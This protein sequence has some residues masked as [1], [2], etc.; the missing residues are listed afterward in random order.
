MYI[1]LT[2]TILVQFFKNYKNHSMKKRII[3]LVFTL[4]ANFLAA[5]NHPPN[6]QILYLYKSASFDDGVV[7]NIADADG[8]TMTAS[9]FLIDEIG[10]Y[11]FLYS[12]ACQEGENTFTYDDSNIA[13]TVEGAMIS[14]TDHQPIDIAEIVALVS[15]DSLLYYMSA[16]EGIR[17]RTTGLTHLED[18]KAG[19]IDNFNTFGLDVRTQDWAYGSYTA[20]NILGKH[21]GHTEPNKL[22]IH[23]AHFDSVSNGPGA[24]DNGSG[25]IGVI[26]AARVLSKFQFKKSLQFIGF[27]LEED[28]LVGSIKYLTQSGGLLASEQLE[29]VLNNE[30]IGYYRTEAG[31]QEMPTGFNILF[32]ATYAAVEQDSFRGNFITNVGNAASQSLI[33]AYHDAAAQYA[34]ELRVLDI[35]APGNSQ[36][37]P[38]LRRSDHAP[39]WDAGYQ[40]LMLTDGSEYRNNNYHTPLDVSDSLNFDFMTNVVRA[41]I[42]TLATLAQPIS[43]GSDTTTNILITMST[44][45][46]NAPKW[47]IQPNPVISTFSIVSSGT[48]KVSATYTVFDIQGKSLKTGQLPIGTSNQQ[49]D[50]ADLP[51]GQYLLQIIGS[52]KTLCVTPIVKE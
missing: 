21:V 8:D 22:L 26:E 23:D 42:A 5:Q 45:E 44:K 30:M 2:S 35:A 41:N 27:D 6:V 11:H 24:D 12:V 50:I 49:V 14:V 47:L 18:V 3:Y 25:T 46:V 38:D 39:F 15:E 17:N 52:D 51:A 40:A 16:I 32:P 9:V 36:I 31:T 29:A 34:P 4:F 10:S 37:A 48:Q 33:T 1:N 43:S 13:F 19:M 20:Q 7:A 28:G